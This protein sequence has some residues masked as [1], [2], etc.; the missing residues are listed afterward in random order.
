MTDADQTPVREGYDRWAQVYDSDRN[1]LVALD[2][3]NTPQLLGDVAGLRV[4]DI[5][6]GTGRHAQR[7]VAGGATVTAVDFSASML[8]KA[9]AKVSPAAVRFVISDVERGLALRSGEFDLVLSALVTDHIGALDVMF[10]ELGRIAR[11]GGRVVVSSMHPAMMLKGVQAR[12]TDPETGVKVYPKSQSNQIC[13][14]VMAAARAG[15]SFEHMSEHVFD[16]QAL[17]LSRP[18]AK[19]Y[20]GWPMLLLMDLRRTN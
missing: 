5:G 12:F 2:D 10:S 13:D 19:N 1:P 7:M 6:C 8:L 17:A 11:P 16:H 3:L 15:L 4:A 18:T 14:Y 9:R 20:L